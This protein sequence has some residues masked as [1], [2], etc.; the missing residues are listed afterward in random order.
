LQEHGAI[1]VGVAEFEGGLYSKDGIDVVELKKYQRENNTIRNFPGTEFIEVSNRLMEYPCDILVPAALENQITAEN[2]PRIQ[3]KIIGE[4]ANG[5]TTPDAEKIL[6]S[7][8]VMVIPDVYLNAGGVTVSYFEWLKNL[9]HVR[10]GRMESRFDAM[11]F[12]RLVDLIERNTGKSITAKERKLLTTGAGELDL[13]RSGLED[14]MINAYA[15]IRETF[16]RRKMPSLRSA[17]FLTALNK[18]GES[19]QDMGIFP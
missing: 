11:Q 6:R 16:K 1:I 14:T 18:V 9:S 4:G 15:D 12:S 3:A 10:F 5:P 17:A 8:G 2:A 19:Y 13:V 7:K